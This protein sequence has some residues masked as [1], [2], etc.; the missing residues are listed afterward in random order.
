MDNTEPSICVTCGATYPASEAPPDACAICE[1]DRQYVGHGGQRWT[2]L[3]GMRA[4][5]Y[6]NVITELEPG[7]VAIRTEPRFAIGQRALLVRTP[8]G[9][10]LW[11]CTSYV[12]EA[13]VSLIDSLG[14]MHAIAISHPHFYTGMA[15]W[16]AAFHGVPVYLHADDRRW[17]QRPADHQILWEGERLE[18][19][20]G[21]TVIRCGGHFPGSAAM[22]WRDGAAGAGVLLSG[23]T[24]MVAQDRG[25][26]SFMHSFPNQIPLSAARVERLAAALAPH[27]FERIF[28]GWTEVVAGGDQIVQE[29][30][31]RYIR[32]LRTG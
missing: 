27:R 32:A 17:I 23:D 15:A 3:A 7:L 14:G 22:H 30:A 1:D 28:D 21:M 20:P 26:V 25:M 2:T 5:G 24:V 6:R 12:D 31:A 29:S 10:L 19:L 4:T 16:S 13:T 9:N 18:P 8:A 11:D